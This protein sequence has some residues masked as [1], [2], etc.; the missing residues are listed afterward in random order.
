ML[1]CFT[2]ADLAWHRLGVTSAFDWRGSEG[3]GCERPWRVPGTLNGTKINSLLRSKLG[4]QK[5]KQNKFS[6]T[7]LSSRHWRWPKLKRDVQLV[8]PQMLINLLRQLP[9]DQTWSNCFLKNRSG[10]L[11]VLSG[12]AKAIFVW[13][14]VLKNMALKIHPHV[15]LWARS[16]VSST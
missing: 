9:Q 11:L 1:R 4:Q 2:W 3:Q 6:R 10:R 16:L 14:V 5:F 7:G 15:G 13:W 12:A 8:E